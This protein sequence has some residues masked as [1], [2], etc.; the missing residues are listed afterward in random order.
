MNKKLGHLAKVLESQGLKLVATIENG[1]PLVCV[2]DI[3]SIKS[4]FKSEDP[5]IYPQ[6]LLYFVF[7]SALPQNTRI[8]RR[9]K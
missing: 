6:D 9:S 5:V 8:T 1:V 4:L 2:R 7:S 3:A